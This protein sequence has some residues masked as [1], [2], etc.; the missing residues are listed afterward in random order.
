MSL[1]ALKTL[2]LERLIELDEVMSLS[3]EARQLATEYTEHELEIPTWLEQ[4]SQL[5]HED[6]AKRTHAADLADLKEAEA[7]VERNRTAGERKAAAQAKVASLQK[8][9]GL[10]A[11]K[12]GK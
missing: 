6:I 9:L 8:K 4:A 10:T 7:E 11:A 1:N 5:L 3:A 12:A 2:A